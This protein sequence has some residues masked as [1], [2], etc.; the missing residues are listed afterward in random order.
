MTARLKSY[1]VTRGCNSKTRIN[2]EE[3]RGYAVTRRLM[4]VCAGGR[5]RVRVRMHAGAQVGVTA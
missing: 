1:A 3:L 4:C 5:A 2:I